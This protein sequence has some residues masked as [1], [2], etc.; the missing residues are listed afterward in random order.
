VKHIRLSEAPNRVRRLGRHIVHDPLSWNFPAPKASKIVSVDHGG[1]GLPLDQADVGCC[2]GDATAAALN[3]MPYFS[4]LGKVVRDQKFALGLYHDETA[5]HPKD[6]VY[7]PEDPGGCGLW[8]AKVLKNRG[9]IKSYSHAFGLE[10][11]L[12]ALVKRPCIF[13][14]NWY[15]SFDHPD[16]TGLVSIKPDAKVDGGH[17]ICA[18]R[19]DAPSKLVWF[20]QS[21]GVWGYKNSGR[22]CMTFDTLDRL[23]K[24]EGD[25]TVFNP[26]SDAQH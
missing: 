8:V 12:L 2:T 20:W 14:V 11:A 21:W 22:F 24:E 5:L 15:S 9:L 26:L 16:K 18:C 13:G 1:E 25:C 17:E 4:L 10:H 23:L 3:C 7:P 6:G 19:I